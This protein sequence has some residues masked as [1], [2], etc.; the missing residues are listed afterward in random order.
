M[1]FRPTARHVCEHGQN[2]QFIVVVP[3]QERIVPENNEA[4]EDDEYSGRECAQKIRTLGARLGHLRRQTPDAQRPTPNPKFRGTTH[5][6]AFLSAVLTLAA[7]ILI[8]SS[9]SFRHAGRL[10]GSPSLFKRPTSRSQ[11]S[12]S[13]SSFRQTRSLGRKPLRDSAGSTAPLL[14]RGDDP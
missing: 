4:E 1:A 8:S 10:A 13:R 2:R 14:D 6:S 3:K 9:I 7:K 5:I 11:R 12:V